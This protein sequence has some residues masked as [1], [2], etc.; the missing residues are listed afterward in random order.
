MVPW[1]S[2]SKILTVSFMSL[3]ALFSSLIRIRLSIISGRP[4]ESSRTTHG[5][6]PTWKL[7]SE[8]KKRKWPQRKGD[9]GKGGWGREKGEKPNI[10]FCSLPR[11]FREEYTSKYS[12]LLLSLLLLFKKSGRR[13]KIWQEKL[14]P[15]SE[16][17]SHAVV[18][19]SICRKMTA[20]F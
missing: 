19:T 20:T 10:S 4:Q 3:K 8:F 12:R 15:P 9:G 2:I 13:K 1:I 14:Q 7:S 6:R 5:I 16:V 11:Y 18:N 17:Y